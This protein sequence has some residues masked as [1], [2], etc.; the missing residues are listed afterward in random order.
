[1]SMLVV[2]ALNVTDDFLTSAASKFT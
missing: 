2:I 1:V